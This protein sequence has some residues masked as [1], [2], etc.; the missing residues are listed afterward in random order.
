MTMTLII[1]MLLIGCISQANKE[2]TNITYQTGLPEKETKPIIKMI[3][4]YISSYHPTLASDEQR[5]IYQYKGINLENNTITY[6]QYKTD[7]MIDHFNRLIDDDHP[8]QI[9]NDLWDN[10]TYM[11]DINNPN[12]WHLPKITL[13]KEL[14]HVNSNKAE[15]QFNLSEIAVEENI[16]LSN[17]LLVDI[18]RVHETAFYIKVTDVNNDHETYRFYITQDLQNYV[19]LD[20]TTEA[21]EQWMT[22]SSF[23]DF[24]E[25]YPQ[26][27]EAGSLLH[28]FTYQQILDIEKSKIITIPENDLLSKDGKYVLLDGQDQILSEEQPLVIQ[29]TEDYI[30]ED[31]KIYATFEIDYKTIAEQLDFKS[32]GAVSMGKVIYFNEDIV[33]LF[34][35]FKAPVAGQ[36]G[37]TNVIIDFSADKDDPTYYVE[38]L[39]VHSFD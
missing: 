18:E 10:E 12:N 24:K 9:L 7:D 29:K 4:N 38:D 39:D 1:S 28:S 21:F 2:D 37:Q 17:E 6:F 30:A 20:D 15:K 8:D 14:L 26:I 19:F 36:A 3:S 16:E 11:Q 5:D 13:E 34:I 27:D 25:L 35:N 23:D 33:V 22:D 32:D 31:D